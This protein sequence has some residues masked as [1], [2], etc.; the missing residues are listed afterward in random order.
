M[1]DIVLKYYYKTYTKFLNECSY[2]TLSDMLTG[3]DL[4]EFMHTFCTVSIAI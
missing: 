2:Q 4:H 3:I 1:Q